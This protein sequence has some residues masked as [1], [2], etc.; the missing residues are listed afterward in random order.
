MKYLY[1]ITLCSVIFSLCGIGLFVGGIN[2]INGHKYP[3]EYNNYDIYQ[4][5]VSDATIGVLHICDNSPSYK[6]N[7]M[8]VWEVS[9]LNYTYISMIKT[10]M[11][12]HINISEAFTDVVEGPKNKDVVPC[13]CDVNYI[14]SYPILNDNNNIDCNVWSACILNVEYVEKMQK[15][16]IYYKNVGMGL[17]YSGM[18]SELI[19]IVIPFIYIFFTKPVYQLP[20]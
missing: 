7:Y 16:A 17:I 13:M 14:S 2:N 19:G 8:A 9:F 15:Q 1:I 3:H 18:I 4:C 5:T 12:H 10:P 11:D 20:Y 6:D